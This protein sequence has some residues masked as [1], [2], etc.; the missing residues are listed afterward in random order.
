MNKYQ[1]VIIVNP[2]LTEEDLAKLAERFEKLI[3]TSGKVDKVEKLGLKKLAY[4]IK[5]A[6]EGYYL[7]YHFEAN[8]DFIAELERNYRITDDVYKFL[9][10][11]EED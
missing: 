2:N 7:T 5:K 10:I 11:R 3:K 6:T 9:T 8:P 4:P 1:S